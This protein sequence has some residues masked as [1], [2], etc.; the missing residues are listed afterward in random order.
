MTLEEI[1]E[2]CPK[3]SI[4]GDNLVRA[5]SKINSS[6]YKKIVCSVSGGSDSDDVID[7]CTMMDNDKKITYVWFDTGL[8]YEATK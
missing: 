2:N 1:L 4:I 5:Y 3:D 7:I 6:K 8:E